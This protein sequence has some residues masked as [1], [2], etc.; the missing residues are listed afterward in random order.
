MRHPVAAVIVSYES[1][2]HLPAC[3]A[4]LRCEAAE[5]VVVDNGSQRPAPAAL[6]R[7]HPE[8]RWIDNPVNRGFAAAV[9]QGAAA[10][11][12]EHILLLNP[13]CE[14]L[15]GLDALVHDCRGE[16]VAGSGGLLVSADGSPQTGFFCRRLPTPRSLAFEALGIN[17]AWP[18]NPVNRRYRMLNLDHGS[19][20]EVEQPAGAFLL[21]RRDAFEEVGGLDEGFHPLWF[22]DVDLCRRLLDAGYRLR[23][24]PA[25]TARHAGGHSVGSLSPEGRQ[26]AW[27]GGMLRYAGKHFPP[28]A[29]RRVR[30]AVLAGLLLRGLYCLAGGG[31][32]SDAQACRAV[33]RSVL[34]DDPAP[35]P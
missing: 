31:S 1:G 27:Y 20:R 4:A 10:T 21:L 16:G 23:F 18:S 14:L 35:L 24:N 9:N 8:V 29:Y 7:R 13:D 32:F 25:A 11:A 17:R 30:G 34:R 15:T 22:E 26:R 5:T 12:A 6:R 3:L 19:A 28:G 2:D 33:C